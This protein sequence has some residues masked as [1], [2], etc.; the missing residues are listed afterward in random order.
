VKEIASSHGKSSSQVLL[1]YLVQQGI[2]VIP[3]SGNQKRIKENSQVSKVVCC[4]MQWHIKLLQTVL[5]TV[6]TTFY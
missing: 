6:N 4:S 3:K 5:H 2:I 1:R